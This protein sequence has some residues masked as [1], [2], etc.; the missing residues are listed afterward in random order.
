MVGPTQFTVLPLQLHQPLRVTGRGARPGAAVDLGCR[1]QLR[2]VSGCIP[3]W[4]ATR[5]IAPGLVAGSCL[6]STAIRVARSRNSS[7]Y[8]LGAAMTLILHGLR[9]STRPGAIQLARSSKRRPGSATAHRCSFFCM[10]STRHSA[11]SRS[12]NR[13]SHGS[14]VFT[15]ALLRL[16]G[17]C[18][19]AGPLRH[20]TGFPGLGLLRV[21]R[22]IPAAS[23]GDGPSRRPA[24]C[25]PGRGPPRWF[26]R[27]LSNRSTG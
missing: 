11:S 2:N 5:E 17:C 26:P 24:G 15:S 12:G 9:A 19:H 16:L 4:P 22:P 20:V 23:A 14:P 27:S 10:L 13:S 21:L 1:T 3:S 18:G 6:N 8:F 25:W 7:L